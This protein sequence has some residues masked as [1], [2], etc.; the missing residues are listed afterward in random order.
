[1][2]AL[3]L[4]ACACLV[5]L[6]YWRRWSPPLLA[7]VAIGLGV[8]VVVIWL[9]Y[10]HT[11]HDVAVSFH[12]AGLL[13]LQRKDPIAALPKYQWNFL[14][15]SAYLFALE[16]KTG[17]PWQVAG[18]LLPV[19]C[20]VATIALVGLL[21]R[22]AVRGN[23]RLLYALCPVAILVSAWHGQIEPIAIAL[24]LSA[25]LLVRSRRD[26]L[27]GFVLGLA[28]ASKT[29]PILF[30][31]GVLREVAW[32]RWWRVLAPI[33]VV[34]ILL[35]GS[36]R[37]VL[38]D[39]LARAGR[40]IL[41][42]RSFFGTWGWTGVL[43]VLHIA[44]IGYSGSRIDQFQRLGTLVT[45]IVL[46]AV[47][48]TFRRCPGPSITVALL[49]GFLAASAGFGIQYLLWPAALLCAARRPTGQIYLLI[50][51]AYAGFFYLYAVPLGSHL[52]G[53][54]VNLLPLGSLPL[55]AAIVAAMPWAELRHRPAVP[56]EE[57]GA[58]IVS[59]L[60]HAAS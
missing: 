57:A 37:F 60:D 28:I 23:A 7:S 12:Q 46:V 34:L 35:F 27:G 8:R 6:A 20:D 52:A 56:V 14:P 9:A 38:E 54:P 17:L 40:T 21:A 45:V 10:G 11:P 36:I 19:V 31:P 41:G 3:V 30:I 48:F 5:V 16:V 42:Y 50:A 53:W 29:W 26:L 43:H 25:L 32:S 2:T 49:L 59:A 39:S 18:K 22:P 1:M 13:V 58:G 55:I 24:G 51:G 4:V 44:G 15:L 47:L 33:G